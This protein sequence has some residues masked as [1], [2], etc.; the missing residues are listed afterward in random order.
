[1]WQLY[2]VIGYLFDVLIELHPVIK[3]ENSHLEIVY[4]NKFQRKKKLHDIF[5]YYLFLLLISFKQETSFDPRVFAGPFL[6]HYS[7]F[8]SHLLHT[9]VGTH[10]HTHTDIH[11]CL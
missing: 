5:T 7:V 2:L 10:A 1:M 9:Y 8:L 3:V 6:Y 4:F 11:T